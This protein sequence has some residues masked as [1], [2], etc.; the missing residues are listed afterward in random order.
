MSLAVLANKLVGG[1][2]AGDA[3]APGPKCAA[4]APIDPAPTII[5][6]CD[7]PTIQ[8][9]SRLLYKL[10]VALGIPLR[11]LIGVG[12]RLAHIEGETDNPSF[13]LCLDLFRRVSD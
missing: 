12:Y 3:L 13:P 1:Q 2:V 8:R 5:R 11:P 7:E 4:G 9:P 6:H 10:L